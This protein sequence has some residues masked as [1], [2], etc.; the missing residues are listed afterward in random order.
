MPGI[1]S[2]AVVTPL[3]ALANDAIASAVGAG[4]DSTAGG[5]ASVSDCSTLTGSVWGD[6]LSCQRCLMISSGATHF[7]RLFGP[8]SESSPSI[9]IA[10]D[11]ASELKKDR[12]CSKTFVF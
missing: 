12:P 8:S 3:A 5:G 11:S 6:C 4:C 10:S 2:S 9:C 7:V 1:F